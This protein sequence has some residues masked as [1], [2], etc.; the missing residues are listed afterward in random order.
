MSCG[1]AVLEASEE[2]HENSNSTD[3]TE[4]RYR[5]LNY[6]LGRE[7]RLL[8]LHAGTES[9]NISC[10]I[11]HANLNDEPAFEAVSYMW[12]VATGDASLSQL[13]YCHGSTVAVTKNCEAETEFC[14]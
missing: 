14:G 12:A 7:V 6:E 13:V 11:V 10:S 8:R 4:Y 9:D 5:H 3:G 2:Q 1:E